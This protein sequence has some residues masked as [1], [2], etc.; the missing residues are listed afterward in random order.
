MGMDVYGLEPISERGAYFRNNIWYWAPLWNYCC[1]VASSVIGSELAD[2][3]HS[4]S[5]AGLDGL[6]ALSLA[7]ILSMEIE[8]GRTAEHERKH[9]EYLASL[10]RVDCVTCEATG[11]RTDA[12][13][14]Q[15][16]QPTKELSQEVQILT[17]RTHGWCNGCNGVGT[18]ESWQM[19]YPFTVENV[20]E[21]VAFLKE[22]GG[23]SIC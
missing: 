23:F 4:N 20:R 3:G 15:M 13:G 6:K 11:I 7:D 22:S 19:H 1:E 8:S 2:H 9:N 10:P 12:V 5:G 18:V 17:G 14:L 16:S 21:F